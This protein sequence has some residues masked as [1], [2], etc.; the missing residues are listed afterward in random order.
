MEGMENRED[1]KSMLPF[2]P[3]LLGSSNLFWP[4]QVVK[5]LET[6]SKGPLYSKV[7]SGELLFDAI[8]HIRDSLALPSLQPVAPFAHGGYALFF[9][10]VHS[11]GFIEDQSNGALEVDFAN[12]YLGGGALRSGCLQ[13]EI[14]FMINPELIAGMLFLPCME[15]NEAIEIVGAERFSNY[16]GYASSFCFSGDHVD[17][18]NVDG[19]RRCKTRIVAIDALCRAG[20]RQYKCTY[21]LREAN[22]AFCGF[23]DQSN[24][25]HHKSLFQDGG[26]QGSQ[27]METDKDTNV[28]VKD[29]PMDEAPSTSVEIAMNRG[30]YINQVIGYSDKKGSWCLDLEDKIGIATG[31]WGCGAFGGD[32]ELKTMIQWL[33]AS[34]LTFLL[35]HT[36]ISLTKVHLFQAAR[37]SVSYYAL[38]I[39]SLQNLNQPTQPCDISGNLSEQS[40][41]KDDIRVLI[42]L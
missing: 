12:K 38:G 1:L 9:D 29:F 37:R 27:C 28:V 23:L 33:A 32:P 34:Q 17:K 22:K 41:Y 39:K 4:S 18:R 25:D 5:S 20:M 7:D 11:S 26:S 36:K 35:F 21:L 2:L 31:N 14:R 19:F 8:S 15:D 3:L 24:C 42:F 10:E 40:Y 13:E 30:E 6:L 16:T